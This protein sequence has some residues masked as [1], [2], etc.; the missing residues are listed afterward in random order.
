MS[1][2]TTEVIPG[3][4]QWI[5]NLDASDYE[6]S[7]YYLAGSGIAIDP[8]L[9]ADE[10][11]GLPGPANQIVI[12][13]AWHVRSVAALAAASGAQVVTIPELVT[14][15]EGKAPG[16]KFETV[17][18]GAAL[19]DGVTIHHVG[20]GDYHEAVIHTTDGG[21]AL[22]AGDA[23]SVID[24][25]L[26]LISTEYLGDDGQTVQDVIKA[27]LKALLALDFDSVLTTHGGPVVGDGRAQLAALL[28]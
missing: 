17:Q 5:A 18:S 10:P 11:A 28:S 25:E 4:F 15:L 7:S 13:S 1:V 14:T 27:D 21:G 12:T 9:S 2:Q 23:L 20:M 22:I 16:V 26:G 6:V 19:A 3:V 24:G 8:Q